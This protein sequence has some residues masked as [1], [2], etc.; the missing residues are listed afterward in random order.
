VTGAAIAGFPLAV[1]LAGAAYLVRLGVWTLR[2][3]RPD[4]R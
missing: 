3:A 1:R 2:S 4:P